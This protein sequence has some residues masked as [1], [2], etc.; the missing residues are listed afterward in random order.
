MP[1]LVPG[2]HVL[3][4]TANK[5]V[6]GRDKP[7]HDG[8]GTCVSKD[9]GQK[10]QMV[11]DAA[12]AAPHHEMMPARYAATAMFRGFATYSFN[13]LPDVSTSESDTS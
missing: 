7:G 2:I 1:G 8:Y 9:E 5:D 13:T 3:G 6:D 11:P 10:R 4:A 12:D